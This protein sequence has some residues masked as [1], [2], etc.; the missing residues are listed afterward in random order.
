MA[1]VESERGMLSLTLDEG[2]SI[3]VAGAGHVLLITREGGTLTATLCG[4][5]SEPRV[6]RP[7]PICADEP[8]LGISAREPAPDDTGALAAPDAILEI[9]NIFQQVNVKSRRVK[10]QLGEDSPDYAFTA[11]MLKTEA[12]DR[13]ADI[14]QRYLLMRAPSG[15]AESE[16]RIT[17][18]TDE[19]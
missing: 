3:R 19:E 12:M 2:E 8:P 1:R 13:V 17:L 5:E 15:A 14:C 7:V 11:G 10:E 9:L 16:P 6:S 4:S 18:S